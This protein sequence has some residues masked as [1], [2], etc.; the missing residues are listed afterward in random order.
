MDHLQ[1]HI[2]EASSVQLVVRTLEE[3][4]VLMVAVAAVDKLG[5]SESCPVH[6]S[7]T[8]GALCAVPFL[9]RNP[10]PAECT[11]ML[12]KFE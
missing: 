2:W 6:I 4:L 10:I 12:K 1:V 5:A 9:A 3:A 7:M 11:R 8:E